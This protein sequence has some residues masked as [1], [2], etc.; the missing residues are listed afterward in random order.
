MELDNDELSSAPVAPETT[1]GGSAPAMD[2]ELSG[3]GASAPSGGALGQG[4]GPPA[5]VHEGPPSPGL[6][7]AAGPVV[8]AASVALPLV[9][10]APPPM[11][12]V[13]KGGLV[14]N[15]PRH[16]PSVEHSSEHARARAPCVVQSAKKLG[17][18]SG[19][20]GA[21]ATAAPRT[22]RRSPTPPPPLGQ[23]AGARYRPRRVRAVSPE[24]MAE[25]ERAACLSETRRVAVNA[26]WSPTSAATA[27]SGGGGGGGVG[28]SRSG[29][30]DGGGRGWG[31]SRSG[32]GD[33]GGRGGGRASPCGGSPF[34][35]PGGCGLGGCGLGGCGL[36][37]GGGGAGGAR[38]S[39]RLAVQKLSSA[40][41][42]AFRAANA[43]EFDELKGDLELAQARATKSGAKADALAAEIGLLQ[44][45]LRAVE[46]ENEKLKELAK[47]Q[48]AEL[49][50]YQLAF[51]KQLVDLKKSRGELKRANGARK[52][53]N[54]RRETARVEA[55][56]GGGGGSGA[57][58]GM[59]EGEDDPAPTDAQREWSRQR[60]APLVRSLGKHPCR[61]SSSSQPPF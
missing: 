50:A 47:E 49:V 21:A 6:S 29:S 13:C 8:P 22:T 40:D 27:A 16:D 7:P 20:G 10:A 41:I 58:A 9:S 5:V 19:G 51:G 4:V 1:A 18:S 55:K 44:E 12:K 45:K 32:S 14:K 57:T 30:G 59:D 3:A 35:G 43:A 34:G 46:N 37:G 25:R 61:S 33:G 38:R 54:A 48:K 56:D 28:R 42:E 23:A 39:S 53:A 15:C 17:D 60:L 11:P 24:L 31:R 36:G 2:L 26:R 52:A